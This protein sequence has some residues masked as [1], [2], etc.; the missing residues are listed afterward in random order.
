MESMD[1]NNITIND[2]KDVDFQTIFS[3]IPNSYKFERSVNN[4]LLI[5]INGLLDMWYPG[6]INLITPLELVSMIIYY[7]STKNYIL[8]TSII[9]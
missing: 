9:T 7:Y 5:K 6:D 1:T 8:F 4:M 2:V 3:V